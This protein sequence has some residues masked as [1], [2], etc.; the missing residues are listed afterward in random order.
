MVSMSSIIFMNTGVIRNN[1]SL[2]K[3]A[4][5]SSQ[6]F[7]VSYDG[8]LQLNLTRISYFSVNRALESTNQ[9]V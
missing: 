4:G 3:L 5:Y 2:S 6:F 7:G 9:A 1:Y 8:G